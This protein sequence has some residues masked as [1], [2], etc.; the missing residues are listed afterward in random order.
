M[1]ILERRVV[2]TREIRL[3]QAETIRLYSSVRAVLHV[4]RMR[5]LFKR[6]T[7]RSDFWRTTCGL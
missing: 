4:C 7:T 6:E 2:Q 1:P 3:C 5:G